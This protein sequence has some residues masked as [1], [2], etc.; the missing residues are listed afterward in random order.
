[1]VVAPLSTDTPSKA[2]ASPHDRDGQT[3]ER[4]TA[5]PADEP[6]GLMERARDYLGGSPAGQYVLG[7]GAGVLQGFTP[8]GFVVP[9]PYA[10]SKP[11]E[12]GRGLGEMA[13][14]ISETLTG[15]GMMGAGGAMTGGGALATVSPASPAGVGMVAVGVPTAIAGAATAANGVAATAAGY[16]V[17]INAMSMADDAGN[18]GRAPDETADQAPDDAR[19]ARIA[20]G[21]LPASEEAAL[22][23][24]LKHIDAG[25]KPPGPLAKRWG[26]QFK[27]WQGDLP[28][29]RG[30]TSPYREYRVSPPAGVTGAGPYR[31]VVNKETGEM[32]YTWTHYGDSGNPA[33]VQIR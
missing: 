18:E 16:G 27:N 21:S 26:I 6:S 31:V 30:P 9:S 23:Q 5:A 24:T 22:S 13:A 15:V 12:L 33:F 4:T 1:V 7:L 11:F 8:G 32:Y 25:T 2:A 14:G 29:A 19:P 10:S 20:P 3:L 17:F 28:G